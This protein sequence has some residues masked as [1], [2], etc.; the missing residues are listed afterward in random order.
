MLKIGKSP[1]NKLLQKLLM[2][3]FLLLQKM[4]KDKAK[5]IYLMMII[6]LTIT[7]VLWNKRLMN[8]T[9]QWNITAQQ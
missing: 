1:T 5:I 7:V 8:P 9:Q 4:L 3:F 2:I 6:E